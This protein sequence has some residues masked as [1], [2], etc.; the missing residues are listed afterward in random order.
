[1]A[2]P[3]RAARLADRIKVVV[4]QAL[5]RRI[6]DPRLG[7]VTLTDA[8]VTNDLQ[9][10]TVYYTVYGD[11]TEAAESRKALESAKGILRSE[12]GR[13]ITARLTPTLEFVPDEIPVNASHLED[14]L[15]TAK[16]RDAEVATLAAEQQYAG[17][18]DPYRRKDDTDDTANSG[19]E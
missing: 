15:R 1:M 4:A 18:S 6:K 7:F 11:D 5:E 10:A 9:H 13:N 14:L 19:N 3:A 12:V 8:R 17:E 2:D 16:E